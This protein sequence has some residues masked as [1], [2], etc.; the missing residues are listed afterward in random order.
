MASTDITEHYKSAQRGNSPVYH[1]WKT[2]WVLSNRELDNGCLNRISIPLSMWCNFS[3]IQLWN[4]YWCLYYRPSP[5]PVNYVGNTSVPQVPQ[6]WHLTQCQENCGLQPCW[7]LWI[8]SSPLRSYRENES[9][10]P[11]KGN[12]HSP[13][14]W[15][16]MGRSLHT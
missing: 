13:K 1:P 10:F 16:L 3:H 5:S 8:E 7:R 12:N 9:A 6:T 14:G 11:P 15:T 4:V 2:K